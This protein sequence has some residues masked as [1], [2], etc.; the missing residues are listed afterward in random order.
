MATALS[1]SACQEATGPT[2]S[3]APD[4]S[5]FGSGF[6]GRVN[7]IASYDNGLAA[8]GNFTRI[9]AVHAGFACSWDGETWTP[10]PWSEDFEAEASAV[11]QDR[12]VIGLGDAPGVKQWMTDRWEPLGGGADG[13]VHF[14]GVWQDKLIAAGYFTEIGGV[15]AENVAMFDGNSW[16]PMGQ[17]MGFSL[18]QDI[19]DH[20][21]DLI[22]VGKLT[23]NVNHPRGAATIARW[24]GKRWSA[25]D[26]GVV[27]S[28]DFDMEAVHSFNG[29][30]LIGGTFRLEP[31]VWIGLA[32]RE[33]D[34]WVE[35]GDFSR[36][37]AIVEYQDRLVILDGSES[38]FS[39]DG[40]AFSPMPWGLHKVYRVDEFAVHKDGLVAIGAFRSTPDAPQVDVARFD[41]TS[42]NVMPEG[43]DGYLSS[44]DSSS[45]Q[46]FVFGRD[47]LVGGEEARNLAFWDGQRWEAL[48]TGTERPI[49]SLVEFNGSLVARS[50]WDQSSVASWDG[51]NWVPMGSEV[52]A[53]TLKVLGDD[54]YLLTSGETPVRRWNGAEWEQVGS[55]VRGLAWDLEIFQGQLYAGGLFQMGDPLVPR[56]LIRLEGETWTAL[57]DTGGRVAS[58]TL[59]GDRLYLAGYFEVDGEYT[60][61]GYFDGASFTGPAG[62][63]SSDAHIARSVG[64]LVLISG[65]TRNEYPWT[66]AFS[67]WNGSG[68]EA[69]HCGIEGRVEDIHL[70]D[71]T[72]VL[73]G[74]VRSGED[75]GF[76]ATARAASM[77]GSR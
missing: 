19:T 63:W 58:M 13:S 48:G 30:L 31:Q 64:D 55:P 3:G 66:G 77:P 39:F 15:A 26:E 22:V 52:G 53:R 49:H 56:H 18:V 47:I 67:I 25:I 54:L 75:F 71:D 27:A 21:G 44:V 72:V 38:L 5:L 33:G 35:V 7:T 40:T 46:I 65:A 68:W 42:W 70:I 69:T 24:D 9:N 1:L 36:T 61:F 28:S 10:F 12:P 57:G 17:G 59:S 37:E 32:R 4:W 60:A 41:G 14:L 76:A 11:Y 20:D 29:E 23:L 34:T 43:P 50:Y 6:N 8:G 51:L 45:D 2:S 73:L 16:H 62:H 74:S